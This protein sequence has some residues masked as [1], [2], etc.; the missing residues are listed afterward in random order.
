MKFLISVIL[1]IVITI[2]LY[3]DTID[4]TDSNEIYNLNGQWKFIESNHIDYSLPNIDDSHFRL[5]SIPG[6]WRQQNIE[7]I[8][9]GWYRRKIFIAEN[10]RGKKI[11]I[12][13]PS[14]TDAHELY[15]NGVK[16]SGEGEIDFSGKCVVNDSRANIVHIPDSLIQVNDINTLA[17]RVCNFAGFAGSSGNFLIGPK[18]KIKERFY[19]SFGWNA[20][21]GLVFLFVAFYH[22]ILFLGSKKDL[23]YFY[24]SVACFFAFTLNTG[25]FRFTYWANSS[26]WFH[27]YFFNSGFGIMPMFL[28]FFVHSFFEYRISFFVRF[29]NYIVCSAFVLFLFSGFSIDIFKIYAQYGQPVQLLIGVPYAISVSI[30][31]IRAI[32]EK[33]DRAKIIGIGLVI[34][35]LAFGN[36][37]LIYFNFV[38]TINL[39]PE[40]FLVFVLSIAVALAAKF[41]S[42]N[43]QIILMQRH[44]SDELE[45]KIRERTKDLEE[46]KKTAEIETGIAWIAQRESQ[47]EKEKT[48]KLLKEIQKDMTT[49]QKIQQNI[50]PNNLDRIKKLKFATLY[51]P[52]SSVGGDYYDVEEIKPGLV[53]AFIADATG[54][55]V[56]AALITMA[57]K[58]EYESVKDLLNS[59]ARILKYLNDNFS[60][61]YKSLHI[62][63]TAFII[64]ID[65]IYDRIT[66]SSAGHAPQILINEN[67]LEILSHRGNIIGMV[68]D[69][70]Y[71]EEV[72]DFNSGRLYLFTDGI[73]EEFN[74]AQDQFGDERVIDVLEKSKSESLQKS[75][76]NL[77]SE[78]L[79]F[80]GNARIRDDITVVGIEYM[81]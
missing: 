74:E 80:V 36:S 45:R 18:V 64:D 33:K 19:R 78:M 10:W 62:Y 27:F 72:K 55:G 32:N 50:L 23:S 43:E 35:L 5:I 24:F 22:M 77:Y 11:S 71:D 29:L 30:L 59:P 58:S 56:Q 21:I 31:I 17:I 6:L 61:K 26:Y 68:S 79:N 42:V 7:D 51:K 69:V 37:L 25:Y 46:A 8:N 76:D 14:I 44:H 49:A 81:G 38:N 1:S 3:A 48:E 53:R 60:N 28:V 47:E 63:F 75:I 20:A 39:L 40:A 13:T 57:I 73:A 4:L 16:I 65:T 2:N 9:T 41:Y 15:L 70:E 67:K 34:L 52:V 66:Y 12:I 54:H